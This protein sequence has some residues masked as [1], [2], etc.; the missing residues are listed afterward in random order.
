MKTC[1]EQAQ[2]RG[3]IA[4][5]KVVKP[6]AIFGPPGHCVVLP[7]LPSFI[8]EHVFEEAV[9]GLARANGFRVAH[10][11][12]AR[13][14]RKGK[15]KYETPNRYDSRGFPDLVMI[16]RGSLVGRMIIAELKVGSNQTTSHQREWLAD[17]MSLMVAGS[18]VEVYEWRE[19]DWPDIVK[20]LTRK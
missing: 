7:E 12:P 17:F 2:E 18:V 15:E 9:V 14:V 10:F 5:E 20:T 11:G 16:R 8:S 4:S 13:V 6:D 1:L 19:T 3:L